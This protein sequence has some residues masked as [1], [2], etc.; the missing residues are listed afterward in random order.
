MP[1]HVKGNQELRDNYR[2]YLIYLLTINQ[3]L[4]SFILN[5]CSMIQLPPDKINDLI[6]I[7][8]KLIRLPFLKSIGVSICHYAHRE[9]NNI[10]K[11]ITW[12]V[13]K[14]KRLYNL[15]FL[16]HR[17]H[18]NNRR[19]FNLLQF[20]SFYSMLLSKNNL[21][22]ICFRVNVKLDVQ[23]IIKILEKH[24]YKLCF[25]TVNRNDEFNSNPELK[26]LLK[27]N[28]HNE[29]RR[30][31]TFVQLVEKNLNFKRT[32]NGDEQEEETE[33]KKQRTD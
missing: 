8:N 1:L 17:N 24:N 20:G 6:Y 12:L 14:N 26:N 33:F 18:L 31:T 29:K 16:E 30:H 22:R 9:L 3:N 19:H 32:H 15:T 13:Q 5:P 2:N 25:L 7:K 21:N 27:R 10:K 4:I 11:M 28:F 23:L